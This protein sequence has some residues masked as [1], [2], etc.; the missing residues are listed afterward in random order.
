ML[1]CDYY[2]P[3]DRYNQIVDGHLWETG[4]YHVSQIEIVQYQ[5]V[6]INTLIERWRPKTHTLYLPV[7]ECA[8]TLEDVA[9]IFGLPTNGLPVTGPTLNS[10]EA[11]E[12]ECLDQFGIA[13]RKTMCSES[14][15][16]L[17]WFRALK[18]HLVLA[19][20]F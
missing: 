13:H 5:S 18:D 4:F 17:T 1:Q 12:A 19:D 9:I 15:I 16:K 8:V 20:D 2:I 6:L 11:L 3:S 14:F 7:G 10:Y